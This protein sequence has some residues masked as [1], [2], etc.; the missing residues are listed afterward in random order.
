MPNSMPEF[1]YPEHYTDDIWSAVALAEAL[2]EYGKYDLFRGQR[3]TFDITPS[4]HRPGV[5]H[6]EVEDSLNHFANWVQ[7]VPDLVS[8]HGNSDAITAVAQHYGLKTP[9]L[10]VTY[11][12]RIAGFFATDGGKSG[13]TGTIICINREHFERSWEN[14]NAKHF[15]AEGYPLTE[16]VEIHVQNLWRLQAQQGAFI[17][18]HVDSAL[19]EMY[20]YMLHIYFPQVS[21]VAI[22]STEE[23]YP[24]EKSHLE[25]LLEQYFLISRYPDRERELEAIFGHIIRIPSNAIEIEAASLFRGNALPKTHSSWKSSFALSWLNE[26]DEKYERPDKHTLIPLILPTGQYLKEIEYE[27]ERTV[28]DTI[29]NHRSD[30]RPPMDWTIE[31]P[32]GSPVFVNGEGVTAVDDEWTEYSMSEAI[33]VIYAGMRNLPYTDCQ[34]ARAI[35][36]YIM[37]QNYGPYE[38]L[39]DPVGVEF[40]GGS[41]RGRGFCSAARIRDALRGDFFQLVKP[42]KLNRNGTL[43][44][45]ELLLAARFVQT[46]YVFEEFVALFVEDLIATQA[47]VAV[48]RLVFGLNP[49]KITIM[50]ES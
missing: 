45:R 10:D 48:E 20:S 47:S 34:V 19:L 25:I 41:V 35:V 8:L 6:K 2:R 39:D 7:N 33:N 15:A 46:V 21:G 16:I 12:P 49:M 17:R 24:V 1:D 42:E 14:L 44:V 13:D 36:R 26:P 32:D 38:V 43:A 37:V 29:A 4:A 30:T 5:N 3:S 18:C 40:E 23:V 22:K 27:V 28:S 50:G 9:F 11:S 31:F